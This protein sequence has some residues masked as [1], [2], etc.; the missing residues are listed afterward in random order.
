MGQAYGL[1]VRWRPVS[2][3]LRGTIAGTGPW[4][5]LARRSGGWWKAMAKP[6]STLDSRAGLGRPA[7]GTSP[8]ATVPTCCNPLHATSQKEK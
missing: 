8:T 1:V 6:A 7:A 2:A 5:L 3:A 4:I